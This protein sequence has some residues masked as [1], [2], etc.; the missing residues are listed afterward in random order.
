MAIKAPAKLSFMDIVTK[1]D[2]DVIRQAL[3]ARVK[4]D[5][6]LVIRDEAYKKILEIENEIEDIC[7][8][9]GAF[10][11]GETPYPVAGLT[12]KK[13]KKARPAT[14]KIPQEE[15]TEGKPSEEVSEVKHEEAPEEVS[16][17]PIEDEES[18]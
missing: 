14:L 16:Y 10:E 11:F 18:E 2:A 9:E 8:E 13:P 4:I 17:E 1:A 12:K 6:L 7:G 5:D 15:S 3:E